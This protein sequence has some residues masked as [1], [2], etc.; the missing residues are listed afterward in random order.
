MIEDKGGSSQV[1][2]LGFLKLNFVRKWGVHDLTHCLLSISP[3]CPSIVNFEL[4]SQFK[5]KLPE[6]QKTSLHL[7]RCLQIPS[8]GSLGWLR[9]P[10]RGGGGP[11]RVC[12]AWQRLAGRQPACPAPGAELGRE[13]G[14]GWWELG[15]MTGWGRA[16]LLLHKGHKSLIKLVSLLTKKHFS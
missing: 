7:I 1:V 15:M 14:N 11:A 3:A 2:W 16:G 10:E 6:E 12:L 9:W 8:G 4:S 13:L 5:P